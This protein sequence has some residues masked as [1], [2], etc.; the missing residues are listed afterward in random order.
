MSAGPKGPGRA[1]VGTPIPQPR[2]SAPSA[3]PRGD[4]IPAD[5]ETIVLQGD[6]GRLVLAMDLNLINLVPSDRDF[7]FRLIDLFRSYQ[8]QPSSRP[9][10]DLDPKP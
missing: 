3:P 9:L 7:V 10:A 2:A 8:E 6:A 5:R 1:I 4:R